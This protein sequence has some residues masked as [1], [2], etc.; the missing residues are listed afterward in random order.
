[1]SIYMK[2]IK[3]RKETWETN[4]SS[5]HALVIRTEKPI[6]PSEVYFD[7]GEFGWEKE[8]YN[9]IDTKCRYLHTAIY[10]R[11]Y[12]YYMDVSKYYEYKDKITEILESYGVKANWRDVKNIKEEYEWCYIDHCDE[13]EDFIE[14]LI[15][16]PELL[17]DWL[18]NS[19]SLLVTDND[20]SEMEYYLDA[21]EKYDNKEGYL[22]YGK[23]N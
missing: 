23:G 6:L 10:Q 9:D 22:F 5:T 3:I 17:I 13:L 16:V 21:E 4:S 20:N 12:D 11:F 8:K 18:F 15:S 1:M 7:V 19:E 2:H 14:M